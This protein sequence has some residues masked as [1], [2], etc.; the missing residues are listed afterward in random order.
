[1]NAPADK[2]RTAVLNV[3]GT[4]APLFSPVC[5]RLDN[6]LAEVREAAAA[7]AEKKWLS[8]LSAAEV[9]AALATVARMR[10]KKEASAS[11]VLADGGQPATSLEGAA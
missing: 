4:D 11:A 8:G 3:L 1:M 10:R 7:A 5:N 9:V 6:M 2:I